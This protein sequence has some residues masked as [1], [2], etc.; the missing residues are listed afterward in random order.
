MKKSLQNLLIKTFKCVHIEVSQDKIIGI[1]QFIMF[2]IVGLTNT[3][4]SYILNILTLLAMHPLKVSWDYIVGNVVSF[5]LSVL[6]SFYWN[7]RFVFTVK[8][9]E[10][11]KIG[12]SLIKT[13]ISYGFTGIILNNLLSGLWINILGVSK[14]IAPLI[15]L[16]ISVPLNF[17]INKFWAF[18][19]NGGMI[20]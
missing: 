6:W 17:V 14:Y 2:G 9:G 11:R 1:T 8:E 5:A 18:R 10:Q 12:R 7:N 4:I 3:I 13:Y 20:I 19:S 15:N 16:I